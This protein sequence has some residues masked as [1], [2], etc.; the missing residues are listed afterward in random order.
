MHLF[1][2]YVPSPRG[3]T[4]PLFFLVINDAILMWQSLQNEQFMVYEYTS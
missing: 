1:Q 4:T 2:Q 3:E